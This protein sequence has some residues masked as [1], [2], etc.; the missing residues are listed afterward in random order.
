MSVLDRPGPS[1][2][3][4]SIGPDW[5]SYLMSLSKRARKILR[6][7]Q[8]SF[9]A[10]GRACIQEPK[11]LDEVSNCLRI[12]E[13][14]HQKRWREK[15][16]DGCFSDD[17]FSCFLSEVT[18][19]HFLSNQLYMALMELDGS[20]AA[21]AIGFWE[22]DRLCLYLVGMDPD[23]DKDKP[24]W[25]LNAYTIQTALS[26]SKYILDFLRGDE[27]Y[28]A[29]L[30]AIGTPQGQWVLAAP[31]AIP[32]LRHAAYRAGTWLE[33]TWE[34]IVQPAGGWK[35]RFQHG[36]NPRNAT[37]LGFQEGQPVGGKYPKQLSSPLPGLLHVQADCS[38]P[39][40][41]L[42]SD[43]V[44]LREL[45]WLSSDWVCSLSSSFESS[46]P[47]ERYFQSPSNGG[48]VGL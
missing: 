15:S 41:R 23:R 8:K 33:A 31:R 37:S 28:K 36:R 13:S 18:R 7:Q 47:N 29:R 9:L 19:R 2:W 44:L 26:R 10:T 3:A 17:D 1:C 5:E 11:S 46:I 21:G 35:R 16:I 42:P 32:R 38:T 43:R 24:G 45:L 39:L 48:R 4:A 30:G 6:T 25:T 27:A 14:L 12:I 20:P 22:D 40:D 34:P